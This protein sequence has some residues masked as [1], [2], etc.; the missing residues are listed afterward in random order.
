M[1]KTNNIEFLTLT[2][3]IIVAYLSNN[4]LEAQEIPKLITEI[5]ESL[6][7]ATATKPD[8]NISESPKPAVNIKKSIK[9]ECLVCLEDGKEFKS[10]KRHL[11]THHQMT[12]EDY[13]AKWNLPKDYPMVAPAYSETRRALAVSIGLGKKTEKSKTKRKK[14]HMPGFTKSQNSEKV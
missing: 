6:L 14:I 8:I 1:D 9:N 7:L 5:H 13:I 11:M 10:L 4:K 12:P 2:S 3:D